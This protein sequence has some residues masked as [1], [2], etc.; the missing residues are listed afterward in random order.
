MKAIV[1]EAKKDWLKTLRFSD[2]AHLHAFIEEREASK[3][4]WI[5][6]FITSLKLFEKWFGE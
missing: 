6:D 1:D 5:Q 2:M 3:E 4:R